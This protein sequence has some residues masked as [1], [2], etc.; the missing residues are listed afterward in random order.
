MYA[1]IDENDKIIQMSPGKIAGIGRVKVDRLIWKQ[2]SI[3][4]FLEGKII[5]YD[6][7]SG[8]L[9]G[10]TTERDRRAAR[11]LKK[12]DAKILL[13]NYD[14]TTANLP[15]IKAAIDALIVLAFTP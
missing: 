7:S 10:D 1:I 5:K 14:S 11:K 15:D 6:I 12:R 13:G 8:G 4:E 2:L 9:V 3:P